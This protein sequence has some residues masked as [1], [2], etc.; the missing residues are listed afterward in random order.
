MNDSKKGM[1]SEQT[2]KQPFQEKNI[3]RFGERKCNSNHSRR[4]LNRFKCGKEF[5][6]L[7][8]SDSAE[9]DRN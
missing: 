7:D 9:E 5:V 6:N 8:V 3:G 4:V 2:L 1:K